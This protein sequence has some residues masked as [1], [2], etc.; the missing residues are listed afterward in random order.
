MFCP[1]CGR[2]VADGSKYCGFCGK[3]L[4]EQKTK[5]VK[6]EIKQKTIKKE[7]PTEVKTRKKGKFPVAVLLLILAAIIAVLAGVFLISDSG[8][9]NVYA[10]VSGGN[11]E[12][13]TNIKKGETAPVAMAKSNEY[14]LRFSPDAKYIFYITKYDD[15]YEKGTAA[16]GKS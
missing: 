16:Q 11:Y 15:D 2:E 12:V 10:V 6:Q 7:K 9:D 8:K 1:E 4:P 5:G 14:F 13:V 3:K